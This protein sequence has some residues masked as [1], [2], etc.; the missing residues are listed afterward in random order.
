MYENQKFLGT[1]THLAGHM[2]IVLWALASEATVEGGAAGL[3]MNI[4]RL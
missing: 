3:A 2:T 4:Q 1:D